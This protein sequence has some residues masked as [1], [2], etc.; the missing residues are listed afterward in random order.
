MGIKC[1]RT[2]S[3]YL[4]SR[5]L[6]FINTIYFLEMINSRLKN[7]E[8]SSPKW[9]HS[10]TNGNK[11]V[12]PAFIHSKLSQLIWPLSRHFRVIWDHWARGY[13]SPRHSSGPLAHSQI[14]LTLPVSHLDNRGSFKLSNITVSPPQGIHLYD[15][16]KS[17]RS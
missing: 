1:A 2:S 17:G 10:L 7:S 11:Y 15:R 4:K 12:P 8:V 5:Y 9:P 3:M 13:F 16:T 6:Y 14:S